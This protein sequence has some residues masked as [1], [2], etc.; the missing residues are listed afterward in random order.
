MDRC[1]FIA[2]LSCARKQF[3]HS[4][5][6]TGSMS[7]SVSSQCAPRLQLEPKTLQQQ[8]LRHLKNILVFESCRQ[9]Q[10]L[11]QRPRGGF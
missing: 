2:R 5:V 3:R 4:P 7:R 6:E 11:H 8:P 10:A 1:C 9:I